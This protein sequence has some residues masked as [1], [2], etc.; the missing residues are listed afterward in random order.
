MKRWGIL[1]PVLTV[2]CVGSKTFAADELTNFQVTPETNIT[3]VISKE[4]GAFDGDATTKRDQQQQAFDEADNLDQAW[5][6]QLDQLKKPD[7]NLSL[8]VD[9]VSPT[10]AEHFE[11]VNPEDATDVTSV[12]VDNV[13]MKDIN[14]LSDL[15]TKSAEAYQYKPKLD[16]PGSGANTYN[17]D[18]MQDFAPVPRKYAGEYYGNESQNGFGDQ[19]NYRNGLRFTFSKPVDNFGVWVGDLETR[20]DGQGTPALLRLYDESL[21]LILE[22]VIKP[23]NIHTD[24]DQNQSV[25]GTTNTTTSLI[26]TTG[27]GH[28]TTRYIGFAGNMP[29]VSYM[30]IIVGDDDAFPGTDENNGNTEHISFM[31]PS[32]GFF[33]L[34]TT[35]NFESILSPCAGQANPASG[36]NICLNLNLAKDASGELSADDFNLSLGAVTSITKTSNNSFQLGVSLPT[37]SY[38]DKNLTINL[39]Q[40]VIAELGNDLSTNLASNS[41]SINYQPTKPILNLISEGISTNSAKLKL[42]INPGQ[43]ITTPVKVVDADGEVIC[44]FSRLSLIVDNNFECDLSSLNPETGY[45]YKLVYDQFESAINFTTLKEPEPDPKPEPEVPSEGRGEENTKPES[46]ADLPNSEQVVYRAEY[47]NKNL[48]LAKQTV[49]SQPAIMIGGLAETGKKQIYLMIA[50][51]SLAAF[52]LVIKLMSILITII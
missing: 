18:T 37:N 13:D 25:C 46:V 17:G 1:L 19:N 10:D 49:I 3:T 43:I 30:I 36:P 20:T 32:K 47:E 31:A 21:S 7:S 12:T 42:T 41:L 35:P 2:L 39:K 50:S 5:K 40:D 4:V 28:N 38:L 33:K 52:A 27:C 11:L 51:L 8:V 14:N 9:Q 44:E 48:S 15:G 16:L 34:K 22:Q 24:G 29:L 45:S 6:D 23:N 26:N